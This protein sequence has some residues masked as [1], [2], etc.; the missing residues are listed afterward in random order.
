MSSA[1]S[2]AACINW[3]A[4][5]ECVCVCLAA[6]GSVKGWTVERVGGGLSPHSADLPCR[7]CILCTTQGG[8]NERATT[9]NPPGILGTFSL[10][11]QVTTHTHT[12]SADHRPVCAAVST[13]AYCTFVVCTE[14][15]LLALPLSSHARA[16]KSAHSWPAG[17]DSNWNRDSK[18]TSCCGNTVVQLHFQW[19]VIVFCCAYAPCHTQIV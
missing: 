3:L 9:P 7:G 8:S 17:Q 1:S 19:A 2:C 11:F 6:G 15:V 13:V 16:F 12:Q 4:G 5:K 18:H 10:W 14:S